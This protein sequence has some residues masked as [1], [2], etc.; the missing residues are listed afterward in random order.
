MNELSAGVTRPFHATTEGR[1]ESIL[2]IPVEEYFEHFYR[3]EEKKHG[4][5]VGQ[6]E[7]SFQT[8]LA[9]AH[10]NRTP[11]EC[12]FYHTMDFGSG[13]IHH[14]AWDLRGGEREYL[15][16]VDLAGQRVLELGPATGYLSFYMEALLSKLAVRAGEPPGVG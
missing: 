14:G 11:A 7:E 13:E 6:L 1:Q 15:G 16:F 5:F 2:E 9:R 3:T 10:A 8:R 4:R 12:H